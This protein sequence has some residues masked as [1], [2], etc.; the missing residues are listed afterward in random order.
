MGE[1]AAELLR[2]TGVAVHRAEQAEKVGPAVAEAARAVFEGPGAAAVL[3]AQKL[4]GIKTFGK[5][6]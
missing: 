5:A 6:S 3:I 1:N 2:L 4:V